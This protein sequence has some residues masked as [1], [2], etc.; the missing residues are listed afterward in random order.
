MVKVIATNLSPNV[1]YTYKIQ[2]QLEGNEKLYTS[3]FSGK[4]TTAKAEPSIKALKIEKTNDSLK[5]YLSMEDDNKSIVGFMKISFDGGETFT[6]LQSNGTLTV[7]DFTGDPLANI[8]V[9]YYFNLN[10]GNGTIE[11][12][13]KEFVV[14]CSVVVV[15]DSIAYNVNKSILDIF[16]N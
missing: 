15:M 9:M 7:N 2:Y 3:Y 14:S 1:T 16:I 8:V 4:V 13:T 10:D 5:V 11:Y 6:N 12:V